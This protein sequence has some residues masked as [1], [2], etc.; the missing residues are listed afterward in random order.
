MK[1]DD[2]RISEGSVDGRRVWWIRHVP[3]GMEVL[4]FDREHGM[5]KLENLVVWREQMKG[6]FPGVDDE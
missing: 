3:S 6:L 5:E 2:L 4:S 1:E